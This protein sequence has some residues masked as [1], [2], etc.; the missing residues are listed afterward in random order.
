ML[1]DG[2]SYRITSIRGCKVIEGAVPVSEFVALTKV[3]SE[4]VDQDDDEWIVD[5]VLANAIGA[6]FV[7]GPKAYCQAWRVEIGRAID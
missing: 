3:W 2:H 5:A 1:T 4:L 6:N 7:L